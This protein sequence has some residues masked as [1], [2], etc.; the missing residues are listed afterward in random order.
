MRRP[1]PAQQ[2]TRV[3][4]S[5]RSMMFLIAAALVLEV[6]AGAGL[7]Y[8]AGFDHVRAAL[9][10]LRPIWLAY[11]AAALTVSLV[12]YY[13]AYRSILDIREGRRP[14]VSRMG[15]VSVVAFG[16]VLAHSG[17]ETE[18]RV[19]RAEGA[20]TRE[21][22]VRIAALTGLEQGVIAIGGFLAAVAVL[23]M[24]R[25]PPPLSFTL[26]W[27]VIPVPAAL[28]VLW[29]AGRYRR[30]LADRN[31]HH[32][33]IAVLLDGIHQIRWHV[34]HALKPDGAIA[35]MALFWAAD[36]LAVW[37]GLAAFGVRMNVAAFFVGFATGMICTRR[38]APLAGAGL[39]TLALTLSIW[40]SGVPLA[41]AAVA[42]FSYRMV[43]LVLGL[44]LAVAPRRMLRSI[45]KARP[46]QRRRLSAAAAISCRGQQ[47][48]NVGQSSVV[49]L[50]RPRVRNCTHG[51]A[52]GRRVRAGGKPGAAV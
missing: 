29:L 23:V 37:S 42:V 40:V 25:N 3:E 36:A 21:A 32:G 44:P 18:I 46:H 7:A 52:P 5:G 22:K 14:P 47:S 15:A 2:R 43:M 4:R 28:V 9:V 10:H 17:G 19:L 48:G 24:G 6:A 35:G 1:L 49:T 38:A 34:V 20:S 45:G 41:T 30:R 33:K 11:L 27:A 26:P 16:G 31:K 51:D 8:L 13:L 12:G 39:L 50:R